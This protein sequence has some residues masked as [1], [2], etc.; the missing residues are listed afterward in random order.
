MAFFLSHGEAITDMPAVTC[1]RGHFSNN[2]RGTSCVALHCVPSAA[3][4]TCR[5]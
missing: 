2:T 5:K 4:A 3:P 1:C